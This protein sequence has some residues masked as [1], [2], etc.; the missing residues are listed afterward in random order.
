MAANLVELDF[1][2]F[3][4]NDRTIAIVADCF[5]KYVLSKGPSFIFPVKK[6]YFNTNS[7][8]TIKGW[9]KITEGYFFHP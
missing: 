2:F 5:H 9:E 6:S 7:G 3:G 4:F 8:L 1:S